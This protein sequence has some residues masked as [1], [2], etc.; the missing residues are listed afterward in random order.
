[1]P[2]LI[3]G[4]LTLIIPQALCQCQCQCQ[5]YLQAHETMLVVAKRSIGTQPNRSKRIER[6]PNGTSTDGGTRT[7]SCQILVREHLS[8]E[9]AIRSITDG[10]QLRSL[11]KTPAVSILGYSQQGKGI[12]L[13]RERSCFPRTLAVFLETAKRSFKVFKE[14]V[15]PHLFSS[16]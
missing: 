3:H 14:G 9:A 16:C 13:A 5:G 15:W 4:P 11:L 12:S 10:T 8:H 6:T 2:T 7:L 1:M